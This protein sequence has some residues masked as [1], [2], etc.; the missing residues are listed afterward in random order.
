MQAEAR[1]D[2]TDYGD[3]RVIDCDFTDRI[4]GEQLVIEREANSTDGD[5]QQ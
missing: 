4:A 3:Q 2:G 1:A 5:E